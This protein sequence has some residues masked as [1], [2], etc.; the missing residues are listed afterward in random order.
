MRVNVTHRSD[1]SS[2]STFPPHSHL[3]FFR[4]ASTQSQ[5]W[6]ILSCASSQSPE[7]EADN[8][9]PKEEGQCARNHISGDPSRSHFGACIWRQETNP[10]RFWH[11]FCLRSDTAAHVRSH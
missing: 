7:G 5:G 8:D 4:H 1:T 11:A 10:N 2:L 3:F 6:F 9:T